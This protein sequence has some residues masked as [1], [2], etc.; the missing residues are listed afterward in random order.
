ME[1]F[2]ADKGVSISSQLFTSPTVLPGKALDAAG[3]D[4]C[5]RHVL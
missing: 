1:A 3:T 5:Y 2:L 4:T